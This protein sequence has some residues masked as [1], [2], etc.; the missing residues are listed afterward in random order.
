MDHRTP[1]Q[2]L[3]DKISSNISVFFEDTFE[4][5][6]FRSVP[7]TSN[8]Y[9]KFKGGREYKIHFSAKVLNEGCS[10]GMKFRKRD[11]TITNY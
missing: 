3:I 8:L 5:I 9:A 2:V 7:G 6:A 10:K 11:M 1:Y 4:D